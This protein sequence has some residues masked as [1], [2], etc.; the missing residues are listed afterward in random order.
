MDRGTSP[1]AWCCRP[2]VCDHGGRALWVSSN[3]PAWVLSFRQ[4]T[5]CASR[6]CINDPLIALQRRGLKD[7]FPQQ[8]AGGG[9]LGGIGEVVPISAVYP[10]WYAIRGMLCIMIGPF[11][12]GGSSNGLYMRVAAVLVRHSM[13]YMWPSEYWSISPELKILPT[14]GYY[15]LTFITSH[16]SLHQIASM[17][18]NPW[19]T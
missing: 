9:I 16:H 17:I 11:V 15:T 7:G 14:I 1:I 13:G 19:V 2:P 18:W 6:I 10:A 4:S 8:A 3:F 5:V 12:L